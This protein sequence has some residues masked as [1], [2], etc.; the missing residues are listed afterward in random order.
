MSIHK[1]IKRTKHCKET[2]GEKPK[3]SHTH[4]I[5]IHAHSLQLFTYLFSRLCECITSPSF[6]WRLSVLGC[7]TI[8]DSDEFWKVVQ[9]NSITCL[10]QRLSF[11]QSFSVRPNTLGRIVIIQCLSVW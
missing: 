7:I 4:T 11:L 6:W 9:R 8:T 2:N 3:D 1:E 10:R 5:Y